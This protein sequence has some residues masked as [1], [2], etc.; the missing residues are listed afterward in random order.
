MTIAAEEVGAVLVGDE[1]KE[2]RTGTAGGGHRCLV[3]A[4]AAGMELT[5]RYAGR[6][7]GG[8]EVLSL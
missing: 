8:F 2:I 7:C 5:G 1:Q 3:N 6:Q 4:G